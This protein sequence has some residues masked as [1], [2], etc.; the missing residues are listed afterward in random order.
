VTPPSASSTPATPSRGAADRIAV[1]A[2]A[3]VILASAFLLF[4]VQPMAGKAIL[5][6]FGGTPAV[7][8]TA[9][10]FF[11]CVLFGGYVYAHLLAQRA[12]PRAQ[13][14]IHV[15]LLASAA[16]FAAGVLPAAS[17]K[18]DGAD[19]PVASIL[20]ILAASVGLPYFCLATTGPL[21]QHW[22][23]QAGLGGSVFRLYALSN[24]GSFAAL[25]SFPYL[26]EP[27]L[28]LPSIA[29]L[30]TA[31]FWAFAIGCATVAVTVVAG[32]ARPGEASGSSPGAPP[33][34]SAA[35][36]PRSASGTSAGAGDDAPTAAPG[37][38]TRLGWVALPALA[39]LA[40]VATTD[41]VSHDI[42]PEP[43]LWITTLALYLLTF[44]LT[45]DHPRWYRP[46]LTAVACVA[47]TVALAGREAIPAALGV[48]WS[49][50]VTALRTLHYAA[51]FA[52]C[53]LCHGELYRRRP[54]EVRHLTEFYLWM[55]AGGACGGLFVALVATNLFDDYHEW[56]L[57]LVAAIALSCAVL[58]REAGRAGVPRAPARA[59]A[60]VALAV[61][62]AAV[63]RWEDPFG[64][65]D[66]S[67]AERT[68]LRLEQ[69]R[70]FYGTVSVAER[71]HPGDPTRDHRVFYSGQIT[72]G[73]QY[74]DPELRRRPVTYYSEDSGIGETLRWVAA[75]QPGAR[76]A[77]VGL[78]AG[79]LATY[80][81][82]ADHY[83]FFEINPDAVRIARRW[84]DNLEACRARTTSTFV[85]DAR[86][87]FERLPDDVRY[88]VIVLDAFTGGSVPTHLLTREAFATW[89]RHLAPGGFI[90]INITNG[91]LN[92][93]PV[94]RAQA[95]LLGLGFRNKWLAADRA[96]LVRQN[97]HFVM[98]RDEAY[99]RA[100]PSV[101]RPILDASGALVGHERLD[102]PGLPL[103]TDHHGSIGAIE[104]RD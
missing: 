83:D 91:Y 13:V 95:E 99:L 81:R 69:S 94:V 55:S 31:G 50:G 65:R 86:L 53:L 79:T 70:N 90:A 18:P 32:R 77:L 64:W 12:S 19:A 68:E 66:R 101:N 17:L 29:R 80:A 3:L 2:F 75:R 28:E 84:F 38:R 23:A 15:A 40:F 6:W 73:I 58:A 44:I 56:P 37:W 67:T 35:P 5:P 34:R 42:A 51:M 8:T 43:R 76:V 87:M 71:R 20:W 47:A 4:Q 22:F 25:L 14:A 46:A 82:E 45:F 16:W 9:M 100:H 102:L 10:L 7:W 26:L 21:L 36:S 54:G 48:A 74:L 33:G 30:W 1:A 11:Q 103:W 49:P 24:L 104:W 72:H 39:S 93:Y 78:G 57:F 60:A 88:D 41:H 89:H 85:G 98:T 92:L 96:R 97:Q 62:A 61:L 59:A 52:A 27:R 63:L